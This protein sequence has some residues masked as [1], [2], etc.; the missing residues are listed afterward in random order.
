MQAL[1]KAEQ[2]NRSLHGL[3]LQA[4]QAYTERTPEAMRS[5][6][7][8]F[9]ALGAVRLED[10]AEGLREALDAQRVAQ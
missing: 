7:D 9:L 4:V 2:A 6:S 5:R 1:G 8:P 10:E 3:G